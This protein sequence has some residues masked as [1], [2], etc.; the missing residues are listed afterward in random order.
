M[1]S[2]MCA[3]PGARER[4]EAELVAEH[5]AGLEAL[6]REAGEREAALSA[7]CAAEL[8]AA[9]RAQAD[10]ARELEVLRARL[11]DT[12][13]ELDLVYNRDMQVGASRRPPPPAVCR[14]HSLRCHAHTGAVSFLSTHRSPRPDLAAWEG[15]AA[16]SRQRSGYSLSEIRGVFFSGSDGALPLPP[17]PPRPCGREAAVPAPARL[18]GEASPGSDVRRF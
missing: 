17:R 10:M 8:A 18:L 9:E 6:R 11:E 1:G 12:S 7:R 5:A 3:G 13:R 2:H 4:R 14:I 15:M 16:A